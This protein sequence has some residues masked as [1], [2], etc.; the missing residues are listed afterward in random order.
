MR[1]G[2]AIAVSKDTGQGQSAPQHGNTFDLLAGKIKVRPEWFAASSAPVCFAAAQGYCP[3][4]LL[5][6]SESIRKEGEPIFSM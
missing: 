6:K 1:D 2:D 5:E 4:S 3:F